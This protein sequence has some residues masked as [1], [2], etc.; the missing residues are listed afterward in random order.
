[1][2]ES[3]GGRER[4]GKGGMCRDVAKER[5]RER[6]RGR[7]RERESGEKDIEGGHTRE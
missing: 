5:E 4:G 3:E 6:E 1:M 2:S 7:E